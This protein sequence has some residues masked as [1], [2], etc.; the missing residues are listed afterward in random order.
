MHAKDAKTCQKR[1]AY[2][3]K[4]VKQRASHRSKVIHT[5][6]WE[7]KL[8]LF[9]EELSVYLQP[10]ATSATC[11]S[12]NCHPI[13]VTVQYKDLLQDIMQA[14]DWLQWGNFISEHLFMCSEIQRTNLH[15]RCCYKHLKIWRLISNLVGL[16]KAMINRS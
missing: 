14:M 5:D 16:C 3:D 4:V 15:Q 9:L 6:C 10:L 2:L 8:C 13:G 12:Q 1:Q 7:K 11:C